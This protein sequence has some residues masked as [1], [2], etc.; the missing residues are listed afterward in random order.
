MP[1]ENFHNN[2]RII[3]DAGGVPMSWKQDEKFECT[4]Y[5][6][7]VCANCQKAEDEYYEEE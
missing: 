3:A 5:N 4:C 7:K 6:G 2:E 1:N